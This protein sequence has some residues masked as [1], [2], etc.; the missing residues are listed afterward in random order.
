MSPHTPTSHLDSLPDSLNTGEM[1]EMS[2][3]ASATGVLT[4]EVKPPF[5]LLGALDPCTCPPMQRKK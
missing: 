1:R 2:L 3:C 4:P 5:P